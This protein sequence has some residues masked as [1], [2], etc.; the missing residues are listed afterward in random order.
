MVILGDGYTV[1]ELAKYAADVDRFL[2]NMFLQD[3][4]L[5]YKAYFNIHRIDVI[6]ADSGIDHPETN[7]FKNTALDGVFN[8]A[9]FRGWC[10]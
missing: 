2:S 3:P 4:Y 8:C 6:S 9:A 7:T 1:D 5:E 10:V